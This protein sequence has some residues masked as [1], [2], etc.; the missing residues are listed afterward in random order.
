MENKEA[1]FSARSR[2][3]VLDARVASHELPPTL[4]GHHAQDF[5]APFAPVP[6]ITTKV[7]RSS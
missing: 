6:P 1:L 2:L 3:R 4:Y 5:S 7:G